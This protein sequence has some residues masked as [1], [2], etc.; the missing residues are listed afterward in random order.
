[1]LL[2]SL[3][4]RDCGMG[5]LLPLKPRCWDF[6]RFATNNRDAAKLLGDI[7]GTTTII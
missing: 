6:P 2:L 1:M 4:I 3:L 5:V 7:E